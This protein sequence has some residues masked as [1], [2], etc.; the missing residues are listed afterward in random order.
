MTKLCK[1]TI[2]LQKIAHDCG[3]HISH[4]IILSQ[5]NPLNI[6]VMWQIQYEPFG[7]CWG[8]FCIFPVKRIF[9]KKG[10]CVHHDYLFYPALSL[11]LFHNLSAILSKI[12]SYFPVIFQ[13][14]SLL[15]LS[16][17][18]INRWSFVL[19]RLSRFRKALRR[20]GNVLCFEAS[21]AWEQL[22]CMP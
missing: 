14:L 7:R 10:R 11:S 4:P 2:K 21:M 12:I 6:P 3:K 20:H 9:T 16:F 22:R 1:F 8:S 5:Q 18:L 13:L 15:S 19:Q 17:Y